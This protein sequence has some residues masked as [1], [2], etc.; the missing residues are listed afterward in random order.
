MVSYK[1]IIYFFIFLILSSSV[2]AITY[3]QDYNNYLTRSKADTLYCHV[4]GSNCN[5]SGG[6]G[7]GNYTDAQAVAAVNVT[8]DYYDISIN[9][10]NILSID[11]QEVY[12]NIFGFLTTDFYNKTETDNLLTT[13][14]DSIGSSSNLWE[15]TGNY[16]VPVN[17]SKGLRLGNNTGSEFIRAEYTGKGLLAIGDSDTTA[18]DYYSVAFGKNCDSTNDGTFCSGLD[19]RTTGQYA[20][21]F[22]RDGLSSGSYSFSSGYSNTAVG[23]GSAAFGYD[24]TV[25]SDAS[26]SFGRQN[27]ISGYGG[28]AFGRV[29]KVGDSGPGSYGVTF[30]YGTQANGNYALAFGRGAY[31]NGNYSII[32]ALDD[33]TVT[34]VTR[35]NVM[36]IM[37]GYLGINNLTP[38]HY[39]SVNGDIYSSDD[40]ITGG[41]VISFGSGQFDNI[42]LNTNCNDGEILKWSG[43]VGTCGTDD[44]GS[45]SENITVVRINTTLS[46][47]R[48]EFIDNSSIHIIGNE[49]VNSYISSLSILNQTPVK[50]TYINE[51]SGGGNYGSSSSIYVLNVSSYQRDILLGFN[52]S[53][54][55]SDSTINSAYISI[56]M[57]TNGLDDN[58]EGFNISATY[59][60]YSWEEDGI[61]WDTR[62][63]FGNVKYDSHY[64]YGGAGEPLGWQIFNVTQIV[65]NCVTDNFLDN[66]TIY[67]V[68]HDMFGSPGATDYL[69]FDS[70]EGTFKP[71]INVSYTAEFNEGF[72]VSLLN[73][74]NSINS[75]I[76]NDGSFKLRSP[77]GKL[78]RITINDN[79]VLETE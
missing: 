51:N 60:N 29:T 40:V 46:D 14:N 23:T 41:D 67:L 7:G 57:T 58:T 34:S 43:G 25:N 28:V 77:N 71:V 38:D 15:T 68:G 21:A 17:L 48:I 27:V 30:G 52:L 61:T 74:T 9:W 26:V 37:G 2:F 22:G 73:T 39:L 47:T 59:Y 55:P 72:C 42:L 64:Y 44:G 16:L 63:P 75:A 8:G 6:G 66:C 49:S 10:S 50:D 12:N 78:W 76:C 18:T 19:T 36:T 33:I 70:K 69:T 20:A 45:T 5:I 31:A 11:W 1:E 53:V 3:T 79:G 65:N 24:N 13:L 4:D 32:W 35:N 56:Y 54:I 62:N